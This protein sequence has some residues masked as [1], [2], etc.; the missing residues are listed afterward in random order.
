MPL[1]VR[2]TYDHSIQ[3]F[4]GVAEC[5]ATST[6]PYCITI[7]DASTDIEDV[8]RSIVSQAAEFAPGADICITLDCSIRLNAAA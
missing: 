7:A 4:S 3:V 2:L 5:P 6:N 8:I 1:K